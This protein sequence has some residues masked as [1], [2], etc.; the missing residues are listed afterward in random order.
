MFARTV[1]RAASHAA[2]IALAFAVCLPALSASGVLGFDDARHLLN[3]TGFAASPAEIGVFASLTREQAV[4]R[5]LASVR[6]ESVT[7]P[8]QWTSEPFQPLRR[9]RDMTPEERMALQRDRR[10]KSLELKA[11]WIEE[12][13][14]TPSPLTEKMTLFWHNHFVSAEQKVRSPHLMYRQNQL[15]RRHALGNFGTLLHEAARDPAMVIY[16]DSASN[17]KAQPNENFAREAMELFTLG[18]GHYTEQDVKEAARAFT[19]WSIDPTS[20]DFMF[21]RFQHDD[22]VKAVLGRQ[23][24]LR[25][26]DVLDIL[27]AHPRTAE[28][29][30]EKLWREFVS[31]RPDPTEVA[32]VARLYRQSGYETTVALKALLTSDAFYAPENRAALIKSPVDLV[33]GTL[34]QFSF[35]TGD[36]LP[37]ALTLAQLGQNLFAP[38]NVKGWPG[39]EA[40]IN[41][42]T[43]LAR[44]QFLEGLFRDEEAAP[45]SA[46]MMRL[47]VSPDLD[48]PR[49][50]AIRAMAEV[51]FDSS[52]WFAQ[53]AKADAA[54]VQG[55]VLAAA[56]ASA[57][58]AEVHGMD[59]LRTLT[60]DAVYQLK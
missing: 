58:P 23:G 32:R 44:K 20:G 49:A 59:I 45:M 37:F 27:L 38:P 35:A 17:R 6:K 21:R 60:Q 52:R 18:E 41:T 40:W 16:L 54:A 39:G 10:E 26:E 2:V 1:T 53:L 24:N 43:L 15:L 7:P 51:R 36:M 33:V 47:S 3:R 42:T 50:R 46:A 11:W 8:P 48:T 25:G 30:V 28:H 31:M 13:R 9:I 56:P 5:L 12:M 22:G 29:V 34:R 57:V 55:V 14:A 4:E 19:G